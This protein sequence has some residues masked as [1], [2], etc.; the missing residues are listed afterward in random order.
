MTGTVPTGEEIDA[1]A[2]S[3]IRRT[4]V[5]QRRAYKRGGSL[6]ARARKAAVD[7]AETY[8]VQRVWLFGSLVGGQPHAESD[9]D[10]LVEGLPAEEWLRAGSRVERWVEAP[11]DLIRVEDASPHLVRHVIA[12]GELLY[13]AA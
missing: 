8:G 2:A 7:L 1:C 6:K 13:D 10:V 3:L 5:E 11:V 4:A 9:V 12:E